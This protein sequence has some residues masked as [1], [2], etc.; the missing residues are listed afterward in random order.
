MIKNVDYELAATFTRAQICAVGKVAEF[1]GNIESTLKADFPS[2]VRGIDWEQF[3]K[4]MT[5]F[6]Q[7]REEDSIAIAALSRITNDVNS[8]KIGILA[9]RVYEKEK[10]LP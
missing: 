7:L 8:G 10:P 3:R 1:V 9:G 6:S 2:S 4:A 5:I